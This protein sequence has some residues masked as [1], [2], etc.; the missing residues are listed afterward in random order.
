MN[1]YFPL[2]HTCRCGQK[3]QVREV[4][5]GD[6]GAIIVKYY[7]RTC[8]QIYFLGYALEMLAASHSHLFGNRPVVPPLK[9]LAAAPEQLT[10]LDN[11]FLHSIGAADEI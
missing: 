11:Q 7:C 6:N 4:G 8:K 2:C 10:L 1:E 9:Q 3:T 5:I